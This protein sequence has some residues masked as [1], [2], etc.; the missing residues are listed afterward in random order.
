[1][2]DRITKEHNRNRTFPEGSYHSERSS[3]GKQQ[4]HGSARDLELWM[5]APRAPRAQPRD[6]EEQ[7]VPH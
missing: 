2:Q 4:A 6:P 1:M 5:R 7:A 3:P